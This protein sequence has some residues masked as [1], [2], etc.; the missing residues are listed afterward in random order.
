MKE[1]LNDLRERLTGRRVSRIAVLTGAGIS[2]ESG[3]P[4]FRGP[5]GLWKNHRP[6]DLATPEAF[7]KDPELV[8]S[9]YA[10]RQG[11]VHGAKPNAAHE[12]LATFEGNLTSGTYYLVT[13]NVDGLHARAGSESLLELH[14]NIFRTRCTRDGRLETI[15][16]PVRDV[17][18]H[19]S[20]GAM[21]RPDV[22]WFGETIELIGPAMQIA[23]MC[24]LL[25]VIGTSGVV[26]PA[27]GLVDLVHSGLTVEINPERT[28]LSD[29]VDVSIR[30]S[31]SAATPSVLEAIAEVLR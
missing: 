6:E 7:R 15:T 10:W 2:A 9:W 20:C 12:A 26:Y 4:T 22:V 28:P 1:E 8:W 31:A 19:C 18:P 11:I 5:G 29:R 30:G 16:E 23:S 21:L 17:P 14:G 13:Q 25:L 3:I 27:A 24:D